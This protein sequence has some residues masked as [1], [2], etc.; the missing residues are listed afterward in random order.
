MKD[1]GE[2]ADRMV[3]RLHGII[4]AAHIHRLLIPVHRVEILF[5]HYPMLVDVL[6]PGDNASTTHDR[7]GFVES[8]RS[9]VS[10]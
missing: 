8:S 1:A 7:E 6:E 3:E 9:M 10:R 2:I 4:I 5:A